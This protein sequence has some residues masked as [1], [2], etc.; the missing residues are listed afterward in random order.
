VRSPS[1]GRTW[2]AGRLGFAALAVAMVAAAASLT[3]PVAY[4]D[5]SAPGTYTWWSWPGTGYSSFE[6]DLTPETDPSPEGIFWSHQFWFVNSDVGGTPTAG[7][8][9]LQTE[10][11][12]PTGKIA[13]LSIW[14]AVS[15]TGPQYA[16]PFSETGGGYTVRLQ[17]DWVVGH[18]YSLSVASVAT[19]DCSPAGPCWS[20]AVQDLSGS[21][22]TDGGA[23][24]VVGYVG[25]P[26]SWGALSGSDGSVMWT[27]LYSGLASCSALITADAR[28]TDVTADGGTVSATFA[29]NSTNEG[30]C[31]GTAS[32]SA[33]SGGV[34]Q[35][36]E[37]TPPG[38]TATP[39]PTP[40][41]TAPPVPTPVPTPHPN[42]VP[43]SIVTP[44]TA[45]TSSPTTNPGTTPPAI[46]ASG[47]AVGG[48]QT[49]APA[50][51]SPAGSSPGGTRGG[52][53]GL[54]LLLLLAA[55][56]IAG[57]CGLLTVRHRQ[58][59]RRAAA[60]GDQPPEL[61]T[62]PSPPPPPPPSPTGP[63]AP[64]VPGPST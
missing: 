35:V 43:T 13:I 56:A 4:A 18:T 39:T 60:G 57:A 20:A 29:S 21:D 17:Y 62:S 28:F 8:F 33:I 54:G 14:N 27:E 31:P 11:S 3:T 40:T 12:D 10:G 24:E 45:T 44:T 55:L 48:G 61:P 1:R 5:V 63:P 58:S 9:G 41:P 37:G 34:E 53:D 64:A 38:P 6:W 42:A 25:V 51:L 15:A 2:G 52:V 22:P 50:A 19:S 26:A 23:I 30:G 46:P 16:Q 32:V 49:P 47:A 36:L 7:Y 59:R